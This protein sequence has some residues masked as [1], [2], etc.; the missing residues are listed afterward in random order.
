M[1]AGAMREAVERRR[2]PAAGLGD[3]RAE[4]LAGAGALHRAPLAGVERVV[5]ASSTPVPA[6]DRRLAAGAAG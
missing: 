5:V 6:R 4:P 3:D 2:A 1:T